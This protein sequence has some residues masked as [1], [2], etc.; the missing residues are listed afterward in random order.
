[1]ARYEQDNQGQ[2]WYYFGSGERRRTRAEII[3]CEWCDGDGFRHSL[4]QK[5][6]RFCSKKCAALALYKRTDHPFAR[7]GSKNP[8][9]RGGRI[10]RKGYVMIHAPEHPSKSSKYVAEHRLV[11][12]NHLG[13]YL[14]NNERVHHINGIKDDN[15]IENLELWETGHPYGQRVEDLPHCET[16]VCAENN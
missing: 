6:A 7:R 15:R 12:E 13:R 4:Q 14:K 9:W 11:M 3:S 1:M 5:P 2:W 8:K 10:V 16:C